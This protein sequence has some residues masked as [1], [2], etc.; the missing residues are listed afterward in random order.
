MNAADVQGRKSLREP[1][2]IGLWHPLT[3]ARAHVRYP[4]HPATRCRPWPQ[5]WGL[6]RAAIASGLQEFVELLA[7]DIP[8]VCPRALLAVP[9]GDVGWVCDLRGVVHSALRPGR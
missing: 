6:M 2:L 7:E 4:P 8:V 1:C 5:V 3:V 9:W